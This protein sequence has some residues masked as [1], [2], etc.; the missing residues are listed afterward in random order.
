M[1]FR[2]HYGHFE[3]VAMFFGLTNVPV[4]FQHMM[5]DVFHEYFDNFV[6]CYINGILIFQITWKMMSTMYILFWKNSEKFV[7]PNWKI[8]DSFNL[9]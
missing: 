5:N 8:V 3:Y 4:V 7:V 9:K 2:I 6:V 1:A